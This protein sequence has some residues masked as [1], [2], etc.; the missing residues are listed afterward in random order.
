MYITGKLIARS[1]P[2]I[3]FVLGGF[4]LVLGDSIGMALILLGVVLQVLWLILR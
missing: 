3:L 2:A 1:P 4:L